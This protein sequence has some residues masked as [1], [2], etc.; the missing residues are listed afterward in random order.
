MIEQS[1]A[2]KYGKLTRPKNE[3]VREREHL[4]PD[5][6]E[7]LIKAAGA[8]GRYG[9]RDATLLLM[10]YRHGLRVSEA[11]ALQWQQVDFKTAHIYI[12]RCKN[13]N[14]S[15]QP[16]LGDELRALRKLQR[17]YPDSSYLFV[18]ERKGPLTDHT[19]RKLV[20]R[21]GVLA[22]LGFPVHPHMLRHATGYHLAAQGVDTRTIQDYLGHKQIQ[23]TVRYTKL[24]PGRFDGIWKG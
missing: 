3:T 13:G 4:R 21:A 22:G 11:I 14:P 17:D 16:I 12:N 23:H 24:A 10:I 20:T 7:L 9:H 15:N 6:M 8:V 5:E 19:V 2:P 18:T 1:Q